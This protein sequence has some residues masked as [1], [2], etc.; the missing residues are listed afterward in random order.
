MVDV[1]L[2]ARYQPVHDPRVDQRDDRV[3]VTGQDQGG[4]PQPGQP[5]QAGP[6]EAG[7]QLVEV[8]PGRAQA[9]GGVQQV[10]GQGRVFPRAAPVQLAGDAGRVSRV[11]VA[12]RREHAQQ[13]ARMPGD[14]QRAWPGRHQHQAAHP[15]RAAQRELLRQPASP[16]D[17]QDVGLL[18]AELVEQ[19]GQQRRQ[20]GQVIGDDRSRRAADARH[21][22]PDDG[23]PRIECVD[24]R[25]EQFQARADAVAQQQRRPARG[26]LP[27]RDADGP[28]ADRQDPHPLGRPGGSGPTR[29]RP[30]TRPRADPARSSAAGPGRVGSM[31]IDIGS[32][33]VADR[34]QPAAAQ[35]R[36]GGLLLAA[37]L[38]Q[39][40]RVV[41]PPGPVAGLR[42]AQPLLGVLR[43]L[44]G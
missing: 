18:V 6:A 38:G 39:P 41:R 3:V 7:E 33:R 44:L 24:E 17:A 26:P 40:A 36:G 22:E 25:L 42:Q 34:R 12:S 28:A 4:R 19:A 9:G 5:R 16:G 32:R 2:A 11:P 21:V 1:Q 10:P 23:T 37:A 15:V 27:H 35:F 31:V 43:A 8:T 30:R 29:R 14:H 13:D 20:R